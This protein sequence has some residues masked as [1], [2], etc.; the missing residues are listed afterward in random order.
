MRDNENLKEGDILICISNEG[1]IT[2]GQE[3]VIHG[4]TEKSINLNGSKTGWQPR[5]TFRWRCYK[6]KQS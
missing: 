2:I 5:K 6:L 4:L 3:R 1:L